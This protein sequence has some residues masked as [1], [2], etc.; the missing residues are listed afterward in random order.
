M[1]TDRSTPRP[2]ERGLHRDD[3]GA[4]LV[5]GLFMC[6]CMVG[7]LWYLAGIGD[8]I[9]YRERLQETADAVAFSGAALNAR[10]MNLIVLINLIMALILAIR[11]ILKAIQAALWLV[12]GI[13]AV[14]PW[15]TA[16]G[17]GLIQIGNSMTSPIQ[18]IGRYID[19]AITALGKVQ[20][21][22]KWIVPPAS[23]FGAAQVGFKYQPLVETVPPPLAGNP[24]LL[25][26]GLPVEPDKD[27]VLCERAAEV[28]SELAIPDALGPVE[29]FVGGML[30]ALAKA[31]GAYFC[32]TTG[33]PDMD[34][35]ET[36][37]GQ[38]DAQCKEQ[39]KQL[40][41]A[42]REKQLAYNSYERECCAN[43]EGTPAQQSELAKRSRELQAAEDRLD[44]FD[45][46]DCRDAAKKQG[47]RSLSDGRKNGTVQEAD[48]GAELPEGFEAGADP[49][50][51]G[52][53]TDT[54]K[55][56]GGTQQAGGEQ[57]QQNQQ[58]DLR[59]KKVTEDWK[60][61]TKDAQIIGFVTGNRDL[62]NL[63][64]A[65][66][67]IGAWHSSDAPVDTFENA[68]SSIDASLFALAQA[69]FFFDCSDKWSADSCKKEAMWRFKWRAR[70]R[71]Y[72]EPLGN[73]FTAELANVIAGWSVLEAAWERR[74]YY[75]ESSTLENASLLL[76]LGDAIMDREFIIH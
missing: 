12:G 4:V 51:G 9:V 24:N 70:L 63:G 57:Q 36:I 58:K 21:A 27:S 16:I 60:N 31:G 52:G 73:G 72:N 65:G 8:A 33:G 75:A 71:R 34:F 61:G 38:A 62:L 53:Q 19:Q 30:G 29:G 11:L 66:V 15:T 74:S 22:I 59:P 20:T 23:A 18:T 54:Q 42:V 68:S 3:R 14:I 50:G 37:K 49:L 41:E 56:Q 46:D 67:K 10:G 39:S 64:A 55:N 25:L 1:A 17:N 32:E 76:E 5:V 43:G 13:L 47:G 40:N 7:A 69:E 35:G 48:G 2:L 28:V 45:E 44:D 26:S 6:T